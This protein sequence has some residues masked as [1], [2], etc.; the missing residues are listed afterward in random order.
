MESEITDPAP[1]NTG[2]I[3][4]PAM[5]RFLIV[6][7]P[8]EKKHKC[9]IA[10]LKGRPDID[11]VSSERLEK[12]DLNG[13][14]L[15]NVEGERDLSPADADRTIVLVD[16]S[17]R[18]AGRVARRMTC[19]RRRIPGFVSAYPRSSK[20]FR[21]PPGGLASAEVLFIAALIMGVRD[22]TLLVGFRW[23]KEFL[24]INRA[25]IERIETR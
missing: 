13:A 14:L 12:V 18:W 8:K 10:L 17:W 2:T 25:A 24:E 9:T 22:E 21:D 15:L 20:V 6:E 4:S 7:H 3:R 16:A 11:F 23:K 19:E 1:K 5:P